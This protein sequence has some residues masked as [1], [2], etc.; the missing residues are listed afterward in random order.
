MASR[1]VDLDGE[2]D[3]AITLLG[4][5]EGSVF[6]IAQE[7]SDTGITV[8]FPPVAQDDLFTVD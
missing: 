4:E 3:A 1:Y 8:S 6:K 2:I 5:F 7:N